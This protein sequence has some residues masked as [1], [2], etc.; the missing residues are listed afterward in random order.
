MFA[1]ISVTQVVTAILCFTLGSV[2]VAGDTANAMVHQDANKMIS[3]ARFTYDSLIILPAYDSGWE[4]VG[5]RIVPTWQEFTHNLGHPQENYRVSLEC[6]DNGTLGTYDCINNGFGVDV[7]WYNLT[8]DS[9]KI[10]MVSG[11]RPDYVRLR[12]Y[13]KPFAYDPGYL[14]LDARPD[15]TSF[16]YTHNLGGDPDNYVAN[17]RCWDISSL[18]H[19]DCIDN[20]FDVNV[21]WYELTDTHIKF[22]TIAGLVPFMARAFIDTGVP[23]Y[24]SGWEPVGILIEP[25]SMSFTHNLGGDPDD[26][27]VRL[28]CRDNGGL[29]TYDCTD[30]NF[31]INAHWYDLTSTT[32]DAYVISGSCPDYV[33]ARI[34][35][36]HNLYA[37][38]VFSNFVET[39]Q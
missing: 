39:Q 32:V 12:I 31:D 3:S 22:Y 7:H 13:P 10:L 35:R 33:R 21:H 9:I 25:T 1:G 36:I 29:G 30:N 4:S 37:P 5:I 34:W 27:L 14:V 11:S 18:K 6:R 28:E 38:L 19:Y 2:I 15:P 26:Y 8:G 23:A 24:D 16:T 20:N 17:V